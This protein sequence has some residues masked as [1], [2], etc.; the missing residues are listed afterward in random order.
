TSG[1]LR[2]VSYGA[3]QSR[4]Y[5]YDDLGRIDTDTLTNSTGQAVTSIDYGYDDN[6]HLTSKKITGSNAADNTYGYD[7]A[8]RLTSWT[9]DGDTT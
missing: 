3:G 5:G 9:A 4:T 1:M 8:G 7:Q 2:R 6:D